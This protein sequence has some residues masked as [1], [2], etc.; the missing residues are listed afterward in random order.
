MRLAQSVRLGAW[1]L[2]GL[3]LLMALGA[4]GVFQRMA[5]AITVILGR[6]DHSIQACEEMLV[7]MVATD[8]EAPMNEDRRILF[9]AAFERAKN[10][11]TEVNE[12]AVLDVI[13]QNLAATFQG[14]PTARQ[15]TAEAIVQ[16]S[17]INHEA[18]ILA[19]RRAQQLGEAGAWGIV[20]MAICVFLVG[21]VFIRRMEQ[22]V[23]HPLEEI[24]AVIAAQRNGETLRRCTGTDLSRD[25]QEIFDGINE[26]LDQ[27][28]AGKESAAG[29]PTT[30]G[31]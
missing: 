25:I 6:N 9:T 27:S 7:S 3:T 29:T 4:I 10:N 13:E 24:H 17:T 16:L 20:F 15:L 28:R 11:V 30:P 21:M 26:M 5:P 12:P 8:G 22:Y 18:M 31:D 14:D 1:L 2:V 19:D 23:M